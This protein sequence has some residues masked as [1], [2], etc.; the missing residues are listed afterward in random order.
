MF[1]LKQ[2][3]CA[4]YFGVFKLLVFSRR[5]VLASS[6][7]YFRS[8]FTLNVVEQNQPE[9]EINGISYDTLKVIVDY[10]YSGKID[11]NVENVQD[12]LTGSSVL[13]VIL[14]ENN[15]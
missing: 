7:P 8:M 10:L 12:L 9:V 14:L 15:L 1:L 13:Q 5:A 11:I 4:V 2:A 3:C 6:S